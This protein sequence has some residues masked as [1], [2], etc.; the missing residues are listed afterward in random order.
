MAA[1]GGEVCGIICTTLF[2]RLQA[3]DEALALVLGL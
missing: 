3:V 1:E 2:R